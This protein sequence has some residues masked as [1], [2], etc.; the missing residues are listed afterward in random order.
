MLINDFFDLEDP[1]TSL[2]KNKKFPWSP[3]FEIEQLFQ[4]K[5]GKIQINI[6]EGVI[7][8][9]PHLIS[10]GKGTLVEPGAFIKGP[11]IIGENCEIR[12]NAYIRGFVWIGNNCIIGHC[13]EVKNSLVFS[14][15]KAAHFAYIG[16]SILGKGVN[17]GAGVKC[18]NMRFDKKSV[19][20]RVDGIKYTTELK[21][22]GT[23]LGDFTQVGCNSV[24]SPGTLL[25]KGC[26]CYPSIN[27]SGHYPRDSRIITQE[28]N[29]YS[30][31]SLSSSIQE[32]S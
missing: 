1:F 27:I 12:A 14:E 11:C 10:I 28:N 19:S 20:V 8:E 31:P 21:K 13:T 32:K 30:R 5:T 29:A 3:L 24:L 18:A 16:D 9:N 25:A 17:L 26:I 7:L 2:Y 15:A 6:P 4:Q 23:I 22:F